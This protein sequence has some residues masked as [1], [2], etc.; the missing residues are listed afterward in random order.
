MSS[1]PVKDYPSLSD[2][3]STPL[4]ETVKGDEHAAIA[5][6][7]HLRGLRAKDP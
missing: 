7:S 3:V 2:H 1:R 5:K 6:L 4:K